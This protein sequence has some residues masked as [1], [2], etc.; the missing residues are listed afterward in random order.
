MTF[1]AKATAR[2]PDR[3]RNSFATASAACVLA[4]AFTQ[5]DILVTARMVVNLRDDFESVLGIEGWSLKTERHE[6]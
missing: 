2:P 6:K 1:A 3:T 5:E 4:E